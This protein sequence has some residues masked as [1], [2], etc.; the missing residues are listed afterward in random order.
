MI[1]CHHWNSSSCLARV[2]PLDRFEE[3]YEI[4]DKKLRKRVIR[5]MLLGYFDDLIDTIYEMN[6]DKNENNK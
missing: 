6:W 3:I 2:S 4:K 5:T 1:G